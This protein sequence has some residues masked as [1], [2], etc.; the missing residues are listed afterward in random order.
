MSL[1]WWA[2]MAILGWI[3]IMA[4]WCSSVNKS[5]RSRS[6]GNRIHIASEQKDTRAVDGQLTM[7]SCPETWLVAFVEE[8]GA[9]NWPK[10][11]LRLDLAWDSSSLSRLWDSWGASRT[12][13]S[14]IM[15]GAVPTGND[16]DL[17]KWAYRWPSIQYTISRLVQ[18]CDQ[19]SPARADFSDIF[20][21]EC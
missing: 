3:S 17:A 13:S 15:Y 6:C 7:R 9:M 4:R 19:L 5:W 12:P 20:L 18:T 14:V 8:T 21:K 2:S 10:P 1:A 16:G 11:K